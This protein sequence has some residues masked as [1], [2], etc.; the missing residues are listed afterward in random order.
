MSKQIVVIGAVALGPKVAA[1]CKRL[2]PDAKVLMVDQGEFISYGGCGMP[3]FLSGEVDNIDALRQ[4]TAHVNRDPDFFNNLKGVETKTHT[5]ALAID[6]KN[7]TITLENLLTDTRYEQSYDELVIATGSSAIVP[8]VDGIDL[9]NIHTIACL[10]DA[11]AIRKQCEARQVENVVVIG[12]GFTGIEVAISLADMWGVKCT[13]LMREE[14]IMQNLVSPTISDMVVNDLASL[15]INVI[16]N[17]QLTAFKGENGVVKEVITSKQTLKAD[18]VIL[19]MGIK[20]NGQLAKEAGL[21]V[22]ERNAIIVNEYLQSSDP[23]IY[24]GGDCVTVK[25]LITNQEDYAPMGSMANRQGRII[26]TNVAGGNPDLGLEKFMGVVGT[27]CIKL[28]KGSAAGTGLNLERAQK[29]G[30]DAI[31]VSMEQLDRAHFYPEKDMMSLEVVVEK[32]TRR[33]LGLQGYCL[34]GISLKARIDTA[35]AMLQ[36]GKPTLNDLSNVEVAYS[37]PLASAMDVI[38]A[39]ANVA[40]NVITGIHKAIS[41][42]EFVELFEKRA[43]NNYIFLDT[44]PKGAG[45]DIA[46][47]YPDHWFALPLEVFEQK[48][49]D[50]PKDKNIALICNSGTRAYECQLMLRRHGLDSLNSSGGMQAMKKRGQD[51]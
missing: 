30:F 49:N 13:L 28:A 27:W 22:N 51:F 6:K 46:Q 23:N 34:N 42:R 32:S 43:E 33:V 47:K 31:S 16:T 26:G 1:R 9:A 4:T 19:A 15:G 8:N 12:G 39:V 50:L 18:Q 40:D 45:D 29:A 20:P 35:A 48:I 2:N 38:N 11:A 21:A 44:R 17:D 25:N 36:F 5:K 3:Y 24:A 10:E 7:K 41:P 14:N 37:P